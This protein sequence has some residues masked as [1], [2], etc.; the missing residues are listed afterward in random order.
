MDE[1]GWQPVRLIHQ[2][3][4]HLVGFVERRSPKKENVKYVGAIVRVRSVEPKGEVIC[5]GRTLQVHPDDVRR[6]L[7]IIPEEEDRIFVLCEHQIL[8]D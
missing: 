7:D 5:G 8:A 3:K 6:F 1:Q 2:C 4:G